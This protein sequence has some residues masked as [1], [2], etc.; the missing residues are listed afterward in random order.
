M[1]P[2]LPRRLARAATAATLLW[3]SVAC[4][5]RP[6]G[7]ASD[8]QPLVDSLVP[9]VELASGMVFTTPPRW[10]I[11]SADQLQE[12]LQYKFREQLPP[13][14]LSGLQTAYRLFGMIPDT[15]QLEPLFLSVLSQQV[16]G[17]YEPDSAMLF[18]VEDAQLGTVITL[19]HELV[20]ALQDQYLPLDS[21]LDPTQPN[22]QLMALQAVLEGQAQYVSVSMLAGPQVGQTGFWD[23]AADESRRAAVGQMK[24]VP[25]VIREALL[26]PYLDGAKFMSWW[27]AGPMADS[28]PYGSL[29][30]RTT[31]QVLFPERYL[32]GDEPVDLVFAD[33]TDAVSYQDGLGEFEIRVLHAQ[34]TGQDRV[35]ASSPLGWNGDRYRVYRSADGPALVW[36]SAW[37]DSRSADRFAEGTA[38]LLAAVPRPDAVAQVDRL[39]ADDIPLVRVV[40]A[41]ESWSYWAAL[42]GV[43]VN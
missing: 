41:P 11:R 30:P 27:F 34:L 8:I 33:S 32:A 7:S 20:H 12:Y 25:L 40:V 29:M 9:E 16:Q 38:A 2:N 37:D 18:L 14:V 39:A 36:Y 22:D 4:R 31:E 10:A 28:M 3:V 24:D 23:V 42:P 17:F 1:V 35:Q 5:G 6:V 19:S 21:L 43:I 13:D 26:F 15:L